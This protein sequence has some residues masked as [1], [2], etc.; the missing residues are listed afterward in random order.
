MVKYC[1]ICGKVLLHILGQFYI[2]ILVDF[3]PK[4]VH[5]VGDFTFMGIF[6]FAGLTDC[7]IVAG[8]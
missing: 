8:S 2:M 6:T 4:F 3:V 5:Y 1:Y 7:M